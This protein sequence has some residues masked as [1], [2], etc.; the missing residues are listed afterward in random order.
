NFYGLTFSQLYVNNNGNVTFNAPLSTYTPFGLTGNIGTPI[1]APFFGDVDTRSGNVASFG[2]S[3]FNGRSAFGVTWDNVGYYS[4]HTDKL[5]S[6]QL[7]LVNRADTGN[8]NFD[9]VF[10]YSTLNWET[11]DASGGYGGLGGLSAHAGF[12]N[13]TGTAGSFYELPGSGVIGGLLNGN[14]DTGLVNNGQASNILGQYIFRVRN[15]DVST[16][17]A[18]FS[19][20]SVT[21][22][23]TATGGFGWS[24]SY[25]VGLSN[26][27][28]RITESI[29]LTGDDPGDAL[30][31]AWEHGIERV[32]SNR[33]DVIDDQG[34]RYPL[35]FDVS[36][37]NGAA[38]QTVTVHSGTGRTNM[39][40]WYTS[41]PGGWPDDRQGEI[42]AHEFGHMV[43]LFDEYA[44]GALDPNANPNVFSNSI[45]A[46]LGPPQP[47]HFETI[48]DLIRTHTTRTLSL[49]NSP[50]PPPDTGELLP[51]FGGTEDAPGAVPEP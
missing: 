50:L 40:N 34:F 13:G 35:I 28:V 11:G 17:I 18:G 22:N 4:G 8:K 1:I 43:G 46:D 29:H 41:M 12:S 5:N 45:M 10:N 24:T 20:E 49:A 21:G 44:G 42:A 48:L 37:V 39:S 26:N 36:F 6:F 14:V 27:Q 9:I 3:T 16:P 38:D 15:G 2:T 19:P 31:T 47:R 7:L 33:Y 32:W 51:N 23:I 30:Q 25:Q